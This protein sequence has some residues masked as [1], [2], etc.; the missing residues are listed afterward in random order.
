MQAGKAALRP[1]SILGAAALLLLVAGVAIAGLDVPLWSDEGS[2][3]GQIGVPPLFSPL[4]LDDLL[5]DLAE[6]DPWHA[7][8]Y[9]LLLRLWGELIGWSIPAL[10]SM[11]LFAMLLALALLY[12]L[13]QQ[14]LSAGHARLALLFTGLNVAGMFIMQSMRPY[15]LVLLVTLLLIR[16]WERL[17]V[18]RQARPWHWP[19]LILATGSVLYTHY[20]AAMGVAALVITHV[21][22]GMGGRRFWPV[23]ACFVVGGLLFLPWS[24]ILLDGLALSQTDLRSTLNFSLSGLVQRVLEQ[25]SNGAESLM[26]L[27]GALALLS[28]RKALRAVWLW[29]LCAT[30]LPWLVSR[31]YPSL[32]G[33]RYMYF[34]WP[35]L[36][37]LAAAGVVTLRRAGFPAWLIP[38]LWALAFLWQTGPEGALREL[39]RPDSRMP[40]NHM[41]QQLQGRTSM[42]DV[43][44]W[45]F[46]EGSDVR[47]EM[48][49]VLRH[50]THGLPKARLAMIEDLRLADEAAY[51]E[52]R[53]VAIA[54]AD[55]IWL[56]WEQAR[57]HWRIGPLTETWLPNLGFVRCALL[58][59][60]HD[61][62][63]VELWARLPENGQ[64]RSWRLA[65]AEGRAIR[66]YV[67]R[68]PTSLEQVSEYVTLMWDSELPPQ[69]SAGLYRLDGSGR[70]L[71]QLDA[72]LNQGRGCH[73]GLLAAHGA[74]DSSLW[75]GVYDW[76][77]GVR[78]TPLDVEAEHNLARIG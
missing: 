60:V 24:G 40:F 68:A 5:T 31:L 46:P 36:G 75:L 1:R 67:H 23:L 73:A 8:A 47:P 49:D 71:A 48:R 34:L 12:S 33:V 74:P 58:A 20:F 78:L 52:S 3:L 32:H 69:Y 50:Y 13:A 29:L 25:F 10:R 17:V 45:H 4:Q 51:L 11:S 43:L 53:D 15:G 2:T 64:A 26:L 54:G 38:L 18:R 59:T 19:F 37:V 9:F 70:L 14:H 35:A 22:T 66:L 41:A 55:R 7:P 62:S 21:A 42:D 27:L 65:D 56:A 44:V 30:L 72:G 39:V 61:P 6:R 28:R 57:R 16:S 77:S 76:R 63:R